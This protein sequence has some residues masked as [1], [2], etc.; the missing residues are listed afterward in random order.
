MTSFYNTTL[1]AQPTLTMKNHFIILFTLISFSALAQRPSVK[2]ESFDGP[3]PYTSLDLNNKPGNF[4]F[5]I[6]TDRTGGHRPGVFLD[7]VK[8][9]NLLQP[10]FVI[11]VGDLIEGYTTNEE[12]LDR[13]WAEFNGFID[14]LQMP[15]F[16]V[17]GNHD[18]TN[19]VMEDK[20]LE[21]YGRTYY[22]FVY[23]DVLFMCL[24]SEDNYRGSSRG[25]IDDEQYEW[26]A[27]TLEENK[28]VKW[29]M[30]FLHQPLWAQQAE[31]LRWPDVEKLL[32]NRKH[33]VYA[34]HRHSYVQYE[35]NNGKYYILAT[36]GG[37][38]SLRGPQFGEFDH[39]VWIT[40]TDEGP[41]MANLQLEGIWSEDMITDDFKAAF[42]PLINRNP[43]SVEPILVQSK[44]FNEGQISLKITNDSDYP[45]TVKLSFKYNTKLLPAVAEQTYEVNPNS[46]EQVTIDLKASD[47]NLNNF[48]NLIMSS[49]VIYSSSNYPEVKAEFSH[50]IRPEATLKLA[51]TSKKIQIDGNLEDW[52]SLKNQVAEQAVLKTDPFSHQGVKDGSFTFDLAY[53]T[54]FLYVAAQVTDNDLNVEDN[55]NPLR[56]DGFHVTLDARALNIS[57]MGT[58]GRETLTLSTSPNSDNFVNTRL[59]RRAS[60]PEGTQVVSKKTDLGYN[61]EM[62]IPLNYLKE[63]QI[64]DWKSIRLNLFQTDYD[65]DFM[66][67]TTISWKP[68]WNSN[69]NYIG[70]GIVLKD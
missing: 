24:N 65:M 16:Y 6:V 63:K 4:Q 46:V 57:A 14:Q 39:V 70:S 28:D 44:T 1:N 2:I 45:M 30:F 23:Q 7:G 22:S 27:K 5:A 59:Y 66:H 37:G 48:K 25:T 20:W 29:T 67:E 32:V 26:I 53:D 55:G 50:A 36:T 68:L 19:K 12:T 60:L 8:K 69:E 18:I 64:T 34:G 51:K 15:F 43:I 56:Q 52:S 35:R 54:D 31:T 10:E 58:G 62:A 41:I 49:E 11:S 33:T 9:L 42:T 61:V 21:M 47:F 13:E 17:P 3:K 40:M 38:S